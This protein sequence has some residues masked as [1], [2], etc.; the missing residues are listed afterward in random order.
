VFY[1]TTT[2]GAANETA[3][4]NIKVKSVNMIKQMRSSTIAANFHSFSKQEARS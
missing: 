2:W 3:A 1:Q 4:V